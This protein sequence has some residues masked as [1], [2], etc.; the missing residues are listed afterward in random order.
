[1][2]LIIQ[3]LENYSNI[4]DIPN[5]KICLERVLSESQNIELSTT[6]VFEVLLENKNCDVV[7]LSLKCIAELSKQEENRKA[8]TVDTIISQLIRLSAKREVNEIY[9]CFRALGNISYE[10]NVARNIIGANG[11]QKLIFTINEIAKVWILNDNTN[12]MTV[13]C[14]C[15]LNILTSHDTLQKVALNN[16]IIETSKVVLSKSIEAFEKQ[17][18]CIIYLL[19]MLSFASDH[20]VD[21]WMSE[22]LCTLLVNIV[23][24]SENMEISVLC[25]D[26]LRQQSDNDDLKFSLAKLGTCELV[27]DLVEKYGNQ[28]EDEDSRAALKLACDLIVLILTGGMF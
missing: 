8:F 26:I 20:M 3:E 9:H 25:L 12:L 6:D 28:I 2:D 14:G 15:L 11:V 22:E 1:M 7:L 23:R 24:I 4:N 10:N 13:L 17:E 21:Q 27:Y 18:D 5:L 16:G 19:Q